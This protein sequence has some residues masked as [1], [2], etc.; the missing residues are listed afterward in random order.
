[1]DETLAATQDIDD[2]PT[3][4]DKLMQA[5]DGLT[6]V[7]L[8][9]GPVSGL[10]TMMLGDFG[11]RV[12]R[13]E[14]PGGDPFRA[15]PCSQM[16]LRGKRAASVDLK[17]PNATDRLR[18]LIATEADAVVT[19]LNDADLNRLTL[20]S[21]PVLCRIRG[22][23][24][25]SD[26][27]GYEGLVAAHVGRMQTFAGI[28]NRKGPGY[29][30]VMVGVH[31]CAQMAASATLAAL[32][33]RARGGHGA[34]V[35]VSLERA[36]LAYDMVQLI[37]SQLRDRGVALP[38][39]A[40]PAAIMP[41]INYH[42]VQCADGRWLQLG[43]L[44]P[45]LLQ[46]FLD[47]VGLAWD[48]AEDEEAFRARLLT[49]MQTR[50]SDEWMQRFLANGSIVAHR[51][52]STQEALN[53]ADVTANGHVV[54]QGSVSQLGVVA[55][56][57]ATPGRVAF[58]VPEPG[59]FALPQT[60]P[61]SGFTGKPAA[62]S[63]G[64]LLEGITVVEFATIIAAPLGCSVLADLGARVIKVETPGGDPFRGMLDGLGAARVNTGKESITLDLKT[65][66]GREAAQR[67]IRSAD[68][69][70]HNFRQGV[71]EKLGID[72]AA[73]RLQRPD[74]IHVA[75]SGYGPDGPG[76][77]R[78]STHPIPGAAM[79]GVFYQL[80]GEPP[81]EQLQDEELR[82]WARKLF[83]ANEVNPDPNTSMVT[84]TAVLLALMA[85]E[86]HGVGQ[87]VSVD[88][89]CANAYAN[90]DD[91]LRYPGKPERPSPRRDQTGFDGY[92]LKQAGDRWV[93]QMGAHQAAAQRTIAEFLT[94][95][96]AREAGLVTEAAHAEWGRYLR[97]GP[98]IV[99]PGQALRG[100]CSVGEHTGAILQEL[101][102]SAAEVESFMPAT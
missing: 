8:G 90:F 18:R 24:T 95:P 47:E 72:Y 83:R 98:L 97:H 31:A 101:G 50:T 63:R 73:A 1:M 15:M 76:A 100:A 99:A 54:T 17:D 19:T 70:V 74:I 30:A 77:R 29:S 27:P 25:R 4:A 57:S 68:V 43:N 21:G 41:T 45:H 22:F 36:L 80:G 28:A 65:D 85:R 88:M 39:I 84:A 52:Q 67:L 89:F 14:P 11:A 9:I 82:D 96:E 35:S 26:L 48:E 33:R 44:L 55:R 16:W 87:A 23:E 58:T 51:Y 34:T 71:P 12:I 2:K 40:N 13:V 78:P 6:I 10:A 38:P 42:P 53:D 66:A 7:E 59:E 60:Q 93:F 49:H 56:L 32:F 37:G 62:P 92:E 5:L 102:Y 75:V 64:T 79:G 81:A 61:P 69:L 3:T 86:R 20:P 94:S 91:F 46:T